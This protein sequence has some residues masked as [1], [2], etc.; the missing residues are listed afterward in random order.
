M[1]TKNLVALSLLCLAS[2]FLIFALQRNWIILNFY[3]DIPK[4]ITTEICKKTVKI[5]FWQN[6][7]QS[8]TVDILW[9]KNKPQKNLEHIIKSWL[10]ILD[11]ESVL[12]K[13]ISVQYLILK[14]KLGYLSLDSNPFNAELSTAEKLK[15]L[16]SLFVTIDQYFPE[17]KLYILVHS[18]PLLDYHL[19]FSS[20]WQRDFF[21]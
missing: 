6:K 4:S 18:D 3:T 1:K 7:W 13:K 2:S 9:D 15:I 5:H 21:S 16:E 8:E 14:E 12:T 11:E 19:D 17:I 10:N 20:P